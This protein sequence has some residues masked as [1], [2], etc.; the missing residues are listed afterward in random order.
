MS[1]NEPKLYGVVYVYWNETLFVH[2][3]TGTDF[4]QLW[5]LE[6]AIFDYNTMVGT[7][8]SAP[9][10]MNTELSKFSPKKSNSLWVKR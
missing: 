1:R 10:G 2:V 6:S 4:L 9:N 3:G 7:I 8:T 5:I